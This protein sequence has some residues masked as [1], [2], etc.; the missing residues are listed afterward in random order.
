[1]DIDQG[2]HSDDLNRCLADIVAG[3]PK[4]AE[5]VKPKKPPSR[6][7]TSQ[8]KYI[9]ASDSGDESDAIKL[10]ISRKGNG[11]RV[12]SSR[13]SSSDRPSGSKRR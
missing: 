1:M 4:K 12:V 8:R 13:G 10:R 11:P 9:E 5:V 2:E 3:G 7:Q 6:W